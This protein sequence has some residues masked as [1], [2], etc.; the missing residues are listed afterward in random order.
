MVKC[1]LTF[2]T[3]IVNLETLTLEKIFPVVSNSVHMT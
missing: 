2:A 1:R 3:V